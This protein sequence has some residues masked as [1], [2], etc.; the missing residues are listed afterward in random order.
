MKEPSWTKSAR[1]RCFPSTV[2]YSQ[3][4]SGFMDKIL[5]VDYIGVGY[6]G[7]KLF[8]ICLSAPF[9]IFFYAEGK[10][11]ENAFKHTHFKNTHPHTHPEISMKPQCP[12]MEAGNAYKAQDLPCIKN[13]H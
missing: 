12:L 2:G 3:G 8:S 1:M 7:I 13:L 9:A 4:N 10:D 6:S 5:T 11:H